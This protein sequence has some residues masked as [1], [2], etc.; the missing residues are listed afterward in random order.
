MRGSGAGDRD[1]QI[2]G[3]PD[4]EGAQRVGR[5]LRRAEDCSTIG[6]VLIPA[7]DVIGWTVEDSHEFSPLHHDQEVVDHLDRGHHSIEARAQ[8][9][10]HLPKKKKKF[11]FLREF[12]GH[13]ERERNG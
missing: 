4:Q 13:R 9:Q 12:K 11:Q 10:S 1:H 7:C 6:P 2:G 5:V 8:E 3:A